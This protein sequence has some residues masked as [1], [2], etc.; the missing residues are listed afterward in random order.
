MTDDVKGANP[1]DALNPR[2]LAAKREY[3]RD[4]AL[5]N[6]A[7]SLALLVECLCDE[8]SYTRDLAEKAYLGLEPPRG[9]LLLPLLDQ[10]LWY[11]RVTVARILGR[12]GHRAAVPGL[13]RLTLDANATVATAARQSLV[14]IG[15]HG[16]AMR[17][18]HALHRAAPELRRRRLEEIGVLHQALRDRLERLMRNEELMGV[19]D[20]DAHADDGP[21]VRSHEEGVDWGLLTGPAPP[22]PEESDR[23][24]A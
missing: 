10:G 3:V 23:R 11:T 9:D 17:V 1:F 19:D 13:M 18:A 22:K 24:D 4:L 6:D 20:P 8:S 5:R 7:Q 12:L 21:V 14:D 15:T 2:G 16:G